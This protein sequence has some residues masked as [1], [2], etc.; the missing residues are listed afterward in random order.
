MEVLERTEEQI[1]DYEL[2]RNKPL[3]NMIHGCIEANLAFQLDIHYQ[4]LFCI[5]LEVTLDTKPKAMTPDICI[6]TKRKLTFKD[7][8][9]VSTEMPLT[10]I[11]IQSPSQA[12]EDL[13]TKHLNTT[14]R[15][16]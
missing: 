11:E 15:L 8:A 10:T 6:F 14:S 1:S 16:A 13:V 12:P 7:L 3:P 5:A 4:H 2:E 9:P